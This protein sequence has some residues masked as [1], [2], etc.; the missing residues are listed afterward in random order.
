MNAIAPLY[1][2]PTNPRLWDGETVVLVGS[3]AAARDIAKLSKVG[4]VLCVGSLFGL[5]P[6]DHVDGFFFG[7]RQQLN[8][9][10]NIIRGIED[11]L[12][13]TTDQ[14][15]RR[16]PNLNV[17]TQR[18]V[19]IT[20]DESRICFNG[21]DQGA[22]LNLA[23]ILGAKTIV[24]AGFNFLNGANRKAIKKIHECVR[25]LNRLKVRVISTD[26]ETAL[27][28]FE[29]IELRRVITPEDSHPEAMKILPTVA[30]DAEDEP[31][32]NEDAPVDA[33][34]DDLDFID[35]DDET[36]FPTPS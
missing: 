25:H 18:N 20:L 14:N 22:L 35:D 8:R 32:Y 23:V 26:E 21:S 27:E 17:L 10:K 31:V 28:C 12:F 9:S 29:Y 30:I 15:A 1:V 4:K 7:D 36:P 33:A 13:F 34:D 24:L 6:Q 3:E 19:G 11:C 2:A 5:V 16:Y